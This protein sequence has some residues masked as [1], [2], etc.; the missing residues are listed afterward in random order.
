MPSPDSRVARQFLRA[1]LRSN[2]PHVRA[3]AR[4]TCRPVGVLKADHVYDLA[5]RA[6]LDLAARLAAALAVHGEPVDVLDAS[7]P[8][9]V[10][11]RRHPF[12][13]P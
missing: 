9:R 13:T 7:P 5:D 2:V 4:E 10:C 3:L 12:S 8:C 1:G 6:A 11:L